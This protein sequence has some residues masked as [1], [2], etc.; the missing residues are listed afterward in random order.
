M[1]YEVE[2]EVWAS[3]GP[4]GWCFLT[5]PQDL[6]EGLRAMRGT[7]VV[8]FGSMRIEATL[9]GTTWRTSLF[10]DTSRGAFLLPLKA[11]VRRRERI[12]PGDRVQ[13]ALEVL[14]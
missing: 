6:A 13:V 10:P 9:G 7:N 5:L 2:G 11:D 4:G 3:G 12:A 8:A 14:L 1:R